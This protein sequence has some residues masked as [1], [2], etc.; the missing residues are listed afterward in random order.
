MGN[1][2]PPI[3]GAV[4]AEITECMAKPYPVPPLPATYGICYRFEVMA[5]HG[6]PRHTFQIF[7]S[8]FTVVPQLIIYDN[9]CKL[10]Q[11]CLNR[12]PAFFGHTQFAVD[13]FHWGDHIGCS[14]GYSFDKYSSI[15]EMTAINSHVN[16]QANAGLQHIKHT[17]LQ[18]ILCFSSVTLA[19]K[20]IDVSCAF[21][22][23][24]HSCVKVCIRTIITLM[25]TI[26]DVQI[27]QNLDTILKLARIGICV[28]A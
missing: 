21:E 17:C 19:V 27:W 2:I 20:N 23:K 25:T 10:H 7:R 8:Q 12:E 13:R 11:Y 3:V 26:V 16:E 6:S 5:T 28:S 24:F 1:T 22:L 14:A 4:I 15:A 18:T 9:A